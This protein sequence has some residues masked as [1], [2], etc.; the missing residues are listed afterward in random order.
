MPSPQK[1]LRVWEPILI[2]LSAAV[3][4]LVGY[5]I[6]FGDNAES[7]FK[8]EVVSNLSGHQQ[9]GRIEEVIRFIENTY[10]DS[11]DSEEMSI[12]VIDQLLEDLDPHSSYITAAELTDHQDRM[13]GVYRGIGIETIGINDTFY[14]SGIIPDSDAEIQGLKSG[15]IINK[16]DNIPVSGHELSFDSLRAMLKDDTRE[17]INIDLVS[18]SGEQINKDV[19][20]KEIVVASASESYLIEGNIGYIKLAR[21]SGNTYEQFVESM[22][23]MTKDKEELDLI[24]DL[25]DNPGGYLPE[26]IKVLSQLFPK[27]DKLLT[28]TKGL[29]REKQ[30]YRS[31]GKNFYNIR[32]VAVLINNYSASGSEILAGAIQDWDRG[33]I[34]GEHSYGKGLVQ[35]IFPLKNGGALRLTVAKYYTPSG[36]LIQKSYESETNEFE[37][38]SL[39]MKSKLL[40]RE[41][42]SGQGVLPDIEVSQKETQDCYEYEYYLDHYVIW[43]MHRANSRQL[44]QLRLSQS[45]YENFVTNYIDAELMGQVSCNLNFDYVASR[46]FYKVI[47]DDEARQTLLSD[48]DEAISLALEYIRNPKPTIA[49]LSNKD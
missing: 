48:N 10:V 25:R 16:V 49:L 36:R 27:K 47:S 14:L 12:N 26:A 42:P 44:D 37:A 20:I 8:S 41:M 5:N 17:T 21:F 38:D 28:Y 31:T 35:E 43:T 2:G 45:G 4:L 13:K 24:L 19:A 30:E 40:A 11:I 7:L 6:Q 1:P 39:V 9:D 18:V 32:K 22:E 15:M 34:I 33:M 29:N 23:K 46:S 3:G